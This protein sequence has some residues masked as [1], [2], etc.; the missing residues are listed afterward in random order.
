MAL[1]RPISRGV[2]AIFRR[3]QTDRELTDEIRDYL[4]RTTAAA[5]RAR[6]P[7]ARCS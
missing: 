2:R 4:D 5:S 7:R 6:P 3:S 1:W